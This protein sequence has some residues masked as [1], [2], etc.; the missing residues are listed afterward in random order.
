MLLTSEASYFP[1]FFSSQ[2]LLLLCT[3]RNGHYLFLLI[4]YR[5]FPL[6]LNT[7]KVKWHIFISF[8]YSFKQN[9]Q[10]IHDQSIHLYSSCRIP[11]SSKHTITISCLCM[12]FYYNLLSL[13]LRGSSVSS[14]MNNTISMKTWSAKVCVACKEFWFQPYWSGFLTQFQCLTSLMVLC[15]MS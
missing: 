9:K 13:E 3:Q 8:I 10:T 11:K 1:F 15:W 12:L 5:L 6:Y 4:L 7:F 14:N 2:F